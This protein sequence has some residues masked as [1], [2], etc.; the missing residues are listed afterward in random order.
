M[1]QKQKAAAFK[2]DRDGAG[3]FVEGFIRGFLGD[4]LGKAYEIRDAQNQLQRDYQWP[5][6]QVKQTFNQVE[7]L[8]VKY[9][10]RLPK[11]SINNRQLTLFAIVDHGRYNNHDTGSGRWAV[12]IGVIGLG[13][14]SAICVS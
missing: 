1:S 3:D 11:N 13:A 4:P 7:E 10:A 6:Q 5:S 12:S 2:A 8:A 14:D 9:G